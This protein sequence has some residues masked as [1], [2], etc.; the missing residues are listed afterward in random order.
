MSKWVYFDVIEIQQTGPKSANIIKLQNLP[1]RADAVVM[2][3]PTNIPSDLSGP[4]GQPIPKP[5][6]VLSFAGLGLQGPGL[7]VEGTKEEVLWKLENGPFV[8]IKQPEATEEPKPVPGKPNL[9][10]IRPE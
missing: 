5:G 7:M 9:K 3:I 2:V 6:V 10:L 4:G 8:E 1:V